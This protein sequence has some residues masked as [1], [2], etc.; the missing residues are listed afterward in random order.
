MV[1][2]F[3]KKL[4]TNKKKYNNMKYIFYNIIYLA[5]AIIIG[6][7][8]TTFE[9]SSIPPFVL[10]VIYL[11]AILWSIRTT[12]KFLIFSNNLIDGINEEV[13]DNKCIVNSVQRIQNEW[14][15]FTLFNKISIWFVLSYSIVFFVSMLFINYD[16]LFEYYNFYA[17]YITLFTLQLI[18]FIHQ[19]TNASNMGCFL[20][21]KERNINI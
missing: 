1:E 21:D 20:S 3:E 7:T 12:N 15:N 11:I 19:Y 4:V 10:G 17:S 8:T 14:Y 13:K 5:I 18:G 6:F 9:A 16:I 2:D